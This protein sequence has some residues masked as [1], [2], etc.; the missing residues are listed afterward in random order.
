MPD[1]A[2]ARRRMDRHDRGSEDLT[3]GVQQIEQRG[4]GAAGDVVGASGSPGRGVT[5]PEVRVDGVVDVG[6]VSRLQPVAVDGRRPPREGGRE[7]VGDDGR[8]LRTRV[9][10]GP[11]HVE[12]AQRDGFKAV[13]CMEDPAVILTRQLADR[14]GRQWLRRHGLDLG[15][16]RRVA[17]SRR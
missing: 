14:I 6:E 3:E 11:E 5:G 12:V 15:K 9:L 13:Q 1:I 2:R 10:A 16:L 8:V 7:E 17:I 4:A